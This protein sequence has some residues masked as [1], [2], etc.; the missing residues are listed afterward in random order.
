MMGMWYGFSELQKTRI[1]LGVV[2]FCLAFKAGTWIFSA[3]IFH[4]E[5][6]DFGDEILSA[7]ETI[8]H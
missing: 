8:W 5:Y 4:P 7:F 1:G 2:S 3:S 6:N